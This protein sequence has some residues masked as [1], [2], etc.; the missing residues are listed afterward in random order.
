M[1]AVTDLMNE[2]ILKRGHAAL[3]EALGPHGA[4]QF[5]RLAAETPKR[6]EGKGPRLMMATGRTKDGKAVSVQFSRAVNWISLGPKAARA[7][8]AKLI[9]GADEVDNQMTETA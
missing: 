9:A 1:N 6:A 5:L 7:M 2:E 3:V 4:L 8:A